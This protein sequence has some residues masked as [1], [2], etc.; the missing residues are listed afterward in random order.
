MPASRIGD[1][2][3]CTG[4]GACAAV[5]PSGAIVLEPGEEGFRYPR[6][7]EAKCT[8]CRRCGDVC[9]RTLNLSH[10]APDS[11]FAMTHRDGKIK[12]KS[13]SGGVFYAL[14]EAV[15]ADGGA[16]CGAA[17]DPD[18]IVRHRLISS[19]D[20]LEPLLG[21][22][23]VQSDI[24]GVWRKI[25]TLLKEGRTVLFAGTPC[26][27]AAARA[28]LPEPLAERLLTCDLL[29]YGTP[30]PAVLAGYLGS[31]ERRYGAKAAGI[32]FRDKRHG[33]RDYSMAVRFDNGRLYRRGKWSDPFSVGFQKHL[34]IA[35]ACYRC[36]YR[37]GRRVGDITLG[38]FWD[39]QE[40]FTRGAIIDD[41]SGISFVSVNSAKGEKLFSAVRAAGNV[42]K[43]SPAEAAKNYGLDADFRLDIPAERDGFFRLMMREGFDAAAEF[44]LKPIRRNRP[45]RK[46]VI[47]F[48]RRFY[49]VRMIYRLVRRA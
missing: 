43:R 21:A 40:R 39:F 19:R 36:P 45:F 33:W 1:P 12:R 11:I 25:R 41:R 31:L 29:C 22:K 38:D 6:L 16:V 46:R 48:L 44:Y 26:Q 28:I 18:L 10:A 4:C 23:Y 32:C 5:C 15:L 35:P 3:A 42:E 14:A 49:T 30:S 13:S 7:I 20:E 9:S 8:G 2:S 37:G 47:L 34:T 27:V 17:V 24:S